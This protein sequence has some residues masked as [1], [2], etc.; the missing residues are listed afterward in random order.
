[1]LKY[2]SR[3]FILHF[4]N[5][6]LSALPYVCMWLFANASSQIADYLRTKSILSTGMTRKVF[7]SLGTEIKI[8]N[9]NPLLTG[10]CIEK[11]YTSMWAAGPFEQFLRTRK[12]F[13]L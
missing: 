6:F 4:Q 12:Y 11:K 10:V 9:F 7:N 2:I 5:G 8:F 1:M 13:L 3:L